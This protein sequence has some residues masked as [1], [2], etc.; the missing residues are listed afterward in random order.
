[1][2]N[3]SDAA[4]GR[5]GDLA[6]WTF[7][8]AVAMADRLSALLNGDFARKREEL[9]SPDPRATITQSDLRTRNFD[10][11]RAERRCLRE[12][13]PSSRLQRSAGPTER[14]FSSL[15]LVRARDAFG[16]SSLGRCSTALLGRGNQFR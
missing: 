9:G 15:H 5:A 11:C 7:F 16:G 2:R 3:S 12:A 4:S 1:M 13:K 14:L 10:A 6:A 8:V